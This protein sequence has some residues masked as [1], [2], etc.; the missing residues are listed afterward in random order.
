MCR[1]VGITDS[2]IRISVGIEDADD[3]INDLKKALDKM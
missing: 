2:M 3:L 1:K